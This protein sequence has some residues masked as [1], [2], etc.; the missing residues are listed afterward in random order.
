MLYVCSVSA[1]VCGVSR[2]MRGCAAS[3]TLSAFHVCV[4]KAGSRR[5]TGRAGWQ[6]KALDDVQV[7]SV[8][9]GLM[10]SGAGEG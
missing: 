8:A 6:V 9:A 5:L 7:I 1:L 4:A 3:V 10:T 2:W